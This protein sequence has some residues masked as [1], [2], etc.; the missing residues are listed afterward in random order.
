M[1]FSQQELRSGTVLLHDYRIEDVLGSGG[2]GITYRARDKRLDTTVAIKE[3]FPRLLAYRRDDQ[4]VISRNDGANGDNLYAWGR[5]KFRQEADSLAQLQHSNIVG[6]NHMFEANNTSYMVLDYIDGGSMKDW[7]KQ[8]K[9]LP[10]QHELD[11]L[12]APLLSALN[13][14]H[15]KGLL[16]RDI[17]PKNIMLA[18][19][20]KP[21]LIDFGAVRLLVAQHSQTV[22]NMLTPGYAPCEQY[23]NRG[24]GPWTDVYALAA[25]FYDAIN[26]SPPVDATERLVEDSNK[27]AAV[28]GRGRYHPQFLAAIDWGLKPK[29]QDRPQTIE[30]WRQG[31]KWLDPS[32]VTGPRPG[33]RAHKPSWFGGLLGR[34]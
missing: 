12:M 6:V 28:I 26:G 11:A 18:K 34:N 31:M 13:A 15:G 19:P 10:E 24:Q 8:I 30:Q 20:F 29:P 32:E 9:R 14:M 16:H 3:Y 4:T 33:A 1:S 17:A 25:T 7:L 21:V 2:F 22:A 23:S 27:P 5:S